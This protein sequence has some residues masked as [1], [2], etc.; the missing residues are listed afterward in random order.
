[1]IIVTGMPRSGTSLIMRLL[2]MLD[3][4]ICGQAFPI[5]KN[6]AHNPSGYFE[7]EELMQG[8]LRS[9]DQTENFAVKVGLQSLINETVLDPLIHK[10]IICTRDIDDM[11]SSQIATG[12]QPTSDAR[13][14]MINQRWQQKF[15][16]YIGEVPYL[17]V[18]LDN[19]RANKSGGVNAIRTFIEA[20]RPVDD[21]IGIIE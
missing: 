13:C 18:N 5:R 8:D 9:I 20:I 6:K 2:F 19:L 17:L 4:H 11:V 16:E 7:D 15:Q 14:K 21:A 3:Y 1:M 12:L 10:V